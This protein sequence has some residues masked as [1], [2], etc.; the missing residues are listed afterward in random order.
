M[1][2]LNHLFTISG[3]KCLLLLVFLLLAIPPTEPVTWVSIPT[4][5]SNTYAAV[6]W[7]YDGL[8]VAVGF[9]SYSGGGSILKSTDYGLSWSRVANS[10]TFIFGLSTKTVNNE[11]YYLSVGANGAIYNSTGDASK[12]STFTL[13]GFATSILYGIV[14]APNGVAF[15][16]G[17]SCTVFR[18][19]LPANSTS[20]RS[21]QLVSGATRT[22]YFY[23]ISTFDGTNIITVGSRGYIYYSTNSGSSWTS[24][25]SGVTISIFCVAHGDAQTAITA[26]ASGFVSRTTNGGSTWTTLQVYGSATITTQYK[27]I[28]FLSVNDVYIASTSGLIYRS[29]N[30]GTSWS[31]MATTGSNIFSISILNSLKGIAGASSVGIFTLV[32]GKAN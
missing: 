10:S 21:Q 7:P 13:S 20:W 18:S 32:A 8:A 16:A 29:S 9:D 17:S 25:S 2:Y 11:T 15:A 4:F 3:T 28:S 19:G 5:V 26:G 14:I 22:T 24:A 31:L 30:G 1:P 27:S 23:D 12:W 6:T